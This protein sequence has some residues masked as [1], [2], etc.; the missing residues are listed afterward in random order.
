MEDRYRGRGGGRT[1]GGRGRA[2]EGGHERREGDMK[3]G[4]GT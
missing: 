4:R 3:G 2:R 1:G